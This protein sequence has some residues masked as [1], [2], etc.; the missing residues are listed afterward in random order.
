[1]L[2]QVNNLKTHFPLVDGAV[3]RAVDG[4]DFQIK[5]GKTLAIVGESGCGK[6]QTAFSIMRLLAPNA[7]HDPTSEIL[8]R[9]ENLLQKTEPQMQHLR[10]N[11]IAMIFQEPMTSLNPL[12]R[13]GN[14]LSEPLLQ[15]RGM[16]VKEARIEALRLLD[17][18]GIPA[19]DTRIDCFPHELSGGMKQ[20]IM[21]A[22]AL[23]CEPDLLIADEPTTALDV[24]IQAQILAL[25]KELQERNGMSIMI[26]T[27][28]LGVVNQIADDVCV[29]YA[30]KVAEYGTRDEIFSNMLHP[31]TRRLLES[32]PSSD[33]LQHKLRTI[34]GMVPSATHY[35][36]GCR[37]HDR[38]EARKV[39]S[40]IAQ[41]C[42]EQA[43]SGHTGKGTTHQVF[44]HLLTDDFST[45]NPLESPREK[46]PDRPQD[47]KTLLSVEDLKTWFPVKKG[48]L[49]R[50]VNHV[51]AVDGLSFEI[52]Q[53]ETLALV[54]E[55]G[56]GKT[57]AGQSLLR[58]TSV[59]P[60]GTVLFGDKPV[61]ELEKSAMKKLRPKMQIVF[62][63]PFASLSPRLSVRDIIEEGLTLHYPELSAAQRVER[64]DDV[65]GTVGL[66]PS[67]AE[68]YP[69]EFSGGQ[70]QR[71]AIARALVLEPEFLVLDEPTSA[72]DVSVQAQILNLL[73]EL[74]VQ[75]NLAYLFIT[76]NLGVVEYL[77]DNVAVMY[78]GKIVEY[79]STKALFADPCHPYTQ[80]LLSA[81]PKVGERRKFNKIVG[82]VPSPLHPP[83]G[84]HFHPRCSKAQEICKTDPPEL[85]ERNGRL[86]ACHF[87]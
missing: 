87:V 85:K 32:I 20:R 42:L 67:V 10:G 34:P 48:L 76:H 29:M 74:Q 55:S 56:C 21:I 11:K 43:P 65:L 77:S 53:G 4:I 2:L 73:E 39:R 35:S 16:S 7:I 3:A 30:G 50:V 78:L 47:Q 51:R 1:M 72:L 84:C 5:E 23:A 75:R 44:C 86:A 81:V 27:H 46:R 13:V 9:G 52:R 33:D 68:R 66:D 61:L 28:D 45:A 25:M 19:P 6:S 14:Q 15:H 12:F 79:A 41:K 18:V 64:V 80:T 24:T 57:T 36:D 63:D 8:F 54:G 17:M 59:D 26:I 38:C 31:Y 71:I 49:M 60:D 83:S 37:F 22:M 69:H 62:Q 82:D 70:R 40:E 58:L